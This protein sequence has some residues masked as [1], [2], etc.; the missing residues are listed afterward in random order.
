MF[1]PAFTGA[2]KAFCIVKISLAW[3]RSTC[4]GK[5]IVASMAL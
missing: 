4:T 3:F 1:S 2:G 5:Y